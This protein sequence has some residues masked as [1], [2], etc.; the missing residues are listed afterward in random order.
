[1]EGTS[2][3]LAVIPAAI[4]VSL[5]DFRLEILVVATQSKIHLVKVD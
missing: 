4:G 2:K 3:T 1:M 5:T